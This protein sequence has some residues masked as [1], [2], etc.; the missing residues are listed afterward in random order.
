MLLVKS[1]VPFDT[2]FTLDDQMR[3]GLC[4]VVGELDGGKFNWA[5]MAFEEP[6]DN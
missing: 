6:K 5:S 4:I 1:G 3:Q 2:A